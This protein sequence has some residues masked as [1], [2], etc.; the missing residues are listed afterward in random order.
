MAKRIAVMI[1]GGEA[2]GTNFCLKMLVYNAIDH[3]Y[4]VVGIRK[5]WEGLITYNPDDPSTHPEQAMLVTK[6]R[7]RDIQFTTG[8]FLH[9]SRLNPSRVPPARAPAFHHLTGDQPV[10]LTHHVKR[11]IEHLQIEGLIVMGDQDALKYAARLSSEGVPLVA[12]PKSVHNGVVGTHICIGFSSAILRGVQ[13]VRDIR[14]IAASREAIAAVEVLGQQPTAGLT[15]MLIGV[16]ADTDHIIIPE[17]PFDP[18]R[19]GSLLLESK[20]M[21]ASNYAI[22]AMSEM[23]RI[24]PQSTWAQQHSPSELRHNRGAALVDVLEQVVNEPILYQPLSYLIRTGMPDGW[25]SVTAVNF[26]LGAVRLVR[27]GQFGRMLAFRGKEGYID[28][29][30]DAVNDDTQA[31]PDLTEFYNA[32]EYT[33]KPTFF[34]LLWI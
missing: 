8:S 18:Q 2:A 16:M 27:E 20:R 25:D 34:E 15:T 33:H 22:F 1:A 4:E 5:G 6:P 11:V 21:H 17:V 14:D 30:I 12:I 28:V 23:C 7:V 19:L 9:T 3:G 26:G 32:S 10:D 13:F 24:D 31:M 29:P